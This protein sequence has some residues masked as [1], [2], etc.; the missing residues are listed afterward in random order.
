MIVASLSAELKRY[1]DIICRRCRENV[2][3]AATSSSEFTSTAVSV[4]SS[5]PTI[6]SSDSKQFFNTSSVDTTQSSRIGQRFRPTSPQHSR[7]TTS[8]DTSPDTRPLLPPPTATD[9]AP[10]N[11]TD[12]LD[13]ASP[14]IFQPTRSFQSKSD[15]SDWSVEYN[16]KMTQCLH[17]TLDKTFT[18]PASVFSAKFS[19]DGKYLAAGLR[20]GETHIYGMITG[21]KRSISFHRLSPRLMK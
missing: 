10:P 13:R 14:S 3:R 18:L 2:I 11:S 1:Q 4:L 12:T 19:R 21:S 15:H 5:T 16:P 8:A 20:N 17:L 7:N 9:S 6:A